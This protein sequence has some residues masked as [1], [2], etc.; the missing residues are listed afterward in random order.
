MPHS[1][2]LTRAF[3]RVEA[4]RRA[5]VATGAALEKA[6]EEQAA[7]F[8]EGNAERLSLAAAARLSGQSERTL[9]RKIVADEGLASWRR[10][11]G[12]Y[13][14]PRLDFL[15]S[16]AFAAPKRRFAAP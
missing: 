3:I 10:D 12:S 2:R 15:A 9:A 16:A 8:A 14:I 1:A 13:A 11:D 5:H 6:L 7:A 4:C